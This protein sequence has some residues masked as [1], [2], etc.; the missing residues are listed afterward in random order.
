MGRQLCLDGK[1]VRIRISEGDVFV[2][3]NDQGNENNPQILV[4]E[5]NQ[6]QIRHEESL[7]NLYQCLAFL[8]GSA[9]EKP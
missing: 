2:E 5:N 9:K 3:W 8:Y 4:V 1:A 6:Y 7:R